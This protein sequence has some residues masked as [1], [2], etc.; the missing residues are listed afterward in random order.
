[1]KKD[2]ITFKLPQL[3]LRTVEVPPAVVSRVQNKV[4][5]V[6]EKKADIVSRVLQYEH[7]PLI[8][9]AAVGFLAGVIVGFALSPVKRGINVLSNND[10]HTEEYADDDSD[11]DEDSDEE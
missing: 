1:M 9:A 10:L 6:R 11:F 5:V 8:T 2:A 4:E 7:T 3:S